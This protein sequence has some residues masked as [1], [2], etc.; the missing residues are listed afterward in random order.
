[1]EKIKVAI[2]GF[3][4]VGREVLPAVSESYD[5]EVAGIV[6]RDPLK[7]ESVKRVVGKIP[8]VT[9]IVKCSTWNTQD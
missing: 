7:V 5:M 4:N 6:L 2:I 1:M 8:V 3:G 9:D